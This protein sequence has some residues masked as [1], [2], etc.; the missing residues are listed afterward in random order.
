MPRI[1][2]LY[3]LQI[4]RKPVTQAF[5]H[6][7]GMT[8]DALYADLNRQFHTWLEEIAPGAYATGRVTGIRFS[9]FAEIEPGG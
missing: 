9:D 3:T 2:R 6:R 4:D 7:V 1:I 5:D 8:A